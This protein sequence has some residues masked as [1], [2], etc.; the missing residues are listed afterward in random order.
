MGVAAAKTI[1]QDLEHLLKLRLEEAKK[2][3]DAATDR[4]KQPGGDASAESEPDR[5]VIGE[6]TEALAEY[7]TVSGI[8]QDLVLRGFQPQTAA[9]KSRRRNR[10]AAT[11]AA[12]SH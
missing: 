4:V 12:F 8:Y 5:E 3:L 1:D 6:Y 10:A 7:V 9:N 11:A 2:R